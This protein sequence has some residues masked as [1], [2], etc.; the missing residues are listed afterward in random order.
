MQFIREKAI[1][2]TV[3]MLALNVCFISIVYFTGH[4]T[5]DLK[6]ILDLSSLFS[7]WK[8]I[9]MSERHSKPNI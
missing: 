2:R 6:N 5:C 7:Q 4:H 3:S 8:K 1:K 9:S